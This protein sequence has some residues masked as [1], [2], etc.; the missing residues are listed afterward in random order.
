MCIVIDTNA[1]AMVFDE[2]N[3]RH[4]DFS[5]IKE[6]IDQ[7]L[8]F[9][10]YGGTKYKNEL[11]LTGRYMKI[12]RLLKDSGQAVMIH[13]DVVNQLEAVV[14]SKTVGTDCDDQHVIA[15][16]GASNCPLLCSVDSRSYPFVKDKGLYPKGCGKVKIFSSKRN[17]KLLKK[18][19][20][21]ILNNVV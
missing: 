5:F 9:V 16:L 21:S 11:S 15:L 2:S 6:W 17:R 19:N 12:I 20:I 14:T 1:L 8:G 4:P 18:T 7:R 13:D 3:S 10:V